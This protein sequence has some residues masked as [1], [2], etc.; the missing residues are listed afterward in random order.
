MDQKNLCLY[1]LKVRSVNI[2]HVFLLPFVCVGAELGFCLLSTTGREGQRRS[3]S[4]DGSKLVKKGSEAGR[5]KE[6]EL[7]CMDCPF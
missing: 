7:R 1:E 6:K 5:G 2:L 4:N 3:D